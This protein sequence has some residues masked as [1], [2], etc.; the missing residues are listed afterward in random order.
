[1]GTYFHILPSHTPKTPPP[2]KQPEQQSTRSPDN[3]ATTPRSKSRST[4]LSSKRP[5]S[6]IA[7]RKPPRL[8]TVKCT[9][10]T[11]TRQ[12][13]PSNTR[14]DCQRSIPT[15][16]YLP[17]NE[18]STMTTSK[19]LSK[20]SQVRWLTSRPQK[21]R[22]DPSYTS[23]RSHCDWRACPSSRPRDCCSCRPERNYS[24]RSRSHHNSRP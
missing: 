24:T 19:I 17:R 4:L 14:R 5:S 6:L 10:T 9:N 7:M 8:L 15:T 13:S 12:S 3:E 21:G 1:M 20:D 23:R 22:T 11:I 2:W 18:S 16:S